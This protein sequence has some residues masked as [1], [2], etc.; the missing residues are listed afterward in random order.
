MNYRSNYCL[1]EEFYLC[2]I[3]TC[4]IEENWPGDLARRNFNLVNQ[5][6]SRYRYSTDRF[7]HNQNRRKEK[8]M[9][10]LRTF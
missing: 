4:Q 9:A 3:E 2:L 1:L 8:R 6:E 7:L 10:I 5:W